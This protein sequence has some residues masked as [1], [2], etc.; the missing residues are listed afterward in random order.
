VPDGIDLEEVTSL[1]LDA[2]GGVIYLLAGKTLHQVCY[3]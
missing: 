3:A 1:S 2:Y